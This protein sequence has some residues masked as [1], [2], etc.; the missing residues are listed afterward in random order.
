VLFWSKPVTHALA[1][2]SR[3]AAKTN[4]SLY[5]SAIPVQAA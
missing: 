1:G 2:Y 5:L 4:P 3:F